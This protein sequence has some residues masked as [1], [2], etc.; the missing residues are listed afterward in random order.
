MSREGLFRH[1]AAVLVA[2]V[3]LGVLSALAGREP[4][5]QDRVR[6][7]M[8]CL[9]CHAGQDSTLAGTA[10]WTGTVHDGERADV[11]CTDCHAGD[12]RHWEEDPAAHPMTNPAK[13]GA[14]GEARLCATCHQTAHQQ[15]ML[16]KNVH[17]V[18]GV[19]CSDCHEVHGSEHP[20]L[21]E[22]PQR[23]LCVEC[24]RQVEG[25][26]ARPYR[27]PVEE[28]VV[29]CTDCHATLDAT[30]RP[31]SPAGTNVC[32][33]CHGEFAGPFPYAHRATLDH[34]TDE[35]G[36]L[37]CHEAHGGALP[38]MLTQPYEAPHAPLCAQCHSVPRHFSN[39]FHGT[40]FA[41]MACND[42]HADIHGSYDNRL[43]VNESLKAQ[44]CFNSGCHRN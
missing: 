44:G 42:C 40:S 18:S 12:R 31:L 37:T 23:A 43:F 7:S 38:R 20:A 11:A 1:L 6:E 41:G 16:E 5:A 34:G 35:G 8:S 17:P 15:N 30:T 29:Q 21:L 26:F 9:G 36:C 33:D 13:V 4:V 3:A 24:H 28:G 32:L 39:P 27:H 2:C 10:H 19:S 22:K 14:P 25:D